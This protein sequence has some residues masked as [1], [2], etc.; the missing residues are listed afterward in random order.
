MLL[1]RIASN[2]PTFWNIYLQRSQMCSLHWKTELF[3]LISPIDDSFFKIDFGPS[4]YNHS[5]RASLKA[6]SY[7]SLICCVSILPKRKKGFC[8]LHNPQHAKHS[9]Y[10]LITIVLNRLVHLPVCII[11]WL[12]PVSSQVLLLFSSFLELSNFIH[13]PRSILILFS[14]IKLD[15]ILSFRS[16][17]SN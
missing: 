10:G 4:T 7:M 14:F 9:P 13:T 6:V 5:L 1:R 11:L 3:I 12:F 8:S 15:K 17:S 2:I 16:I